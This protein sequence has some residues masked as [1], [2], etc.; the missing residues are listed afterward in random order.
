[1]LLTAQL[2]L[3]YQRC[4]RRAFLDVYGDDGQRDPPSDY[5]R[6]LRQDSSAHQQAMLASYAY[7]KPRYSQDNWQEGS[8]ATLSLMAQGAEAIYH[9]VLLVSG[10][11]FQALDLAVS[12]SYRLEKLV[13]L[14]IPGLLVKS[15]GTSAF[16]PWQYALVEIKW[17]KRPKREYQMVAMF[18]AWVLSCLQGC[19]PQSIQLMLRDRSPYYVD[20][21]KLWPEFQALLADVVDAMS[22]PQAPEVF[23]SRQ[24]CSL[25]QW[26]TSCT[27][28]ARESQ[29]LSLVPG[30]TPKRYEVL[31]GLG[32][33]SL[34]SLS[35]DNLG[36]LTAELG[37]QVARQMVR[38]AQSTREQR[39]IAID[40]DRLPPLPTTPVELYFDIETEPDLNLEYLFGVFVLDR[41]ARRSQFYPFL[42]TSFQDQERMWYEFLDLVNH[43]DPMPIFHFCEY[44]VKAMGLLAKRFH[45]PAEQWQPLVHRCVDIHA[46]VTQYVTLPVESYAL[47]AIARSM[48]F[49]WRDE[50]AS[51][52]QT[53]YWYDQ[54]MQTGDR[55][56]LDRIIRYNED[57]CRATYHVKDWLVRNF[58]S[59]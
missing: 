27:T 49:D 24:K 9:G 11:H 22:A 12:E 46:W 8:A 1:M 14:S 13:G 41:T 5:L 4:R 33:T 51:G 56:F 7:D 26:L 55:E 44:E 36:S 28:M 59:L 52:A 21:V 15:P 25:C 54:W 48:G 39:A 53:V 18:H 45:T 10:N 50:E 16:G 23:I 35:A 37:P 57:D 47:K 19:P 30:V 17:G 29:H 6:K 42:A 38:Q 34:E 2:L 3:N 31:Q 43:Y 20:N 32:L 58:D 40:R